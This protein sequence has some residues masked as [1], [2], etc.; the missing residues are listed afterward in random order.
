MLPETMLDMKRAL[1][2][3]PYWRDEV[4]DYSDLGWTSDF[5][6]DSVT[7]MRLRKSDLLNFAVFNEGN[8]YNSLFFKVDELYKT[9]CEEGGEF[10]QF[11][12]DVMAVIREV[13]REDWFTDLSTYLMEEDDTDDNTDNVEYV[14]NEETDTYDRIPPTFLRV[15]KLWSVFYEIMAEMDFFTKYP[16]LLSHKPKL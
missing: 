16:F 14:Y 2:E 3:V 6:V 15:E 11:H 1:F 13:E 4:A 10:C 12:K 9:D 7:N 5:A 8:L